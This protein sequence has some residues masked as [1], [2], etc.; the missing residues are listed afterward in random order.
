M[1]DFLSE[2]GEQLRLAAWRRHDRRRRFG[3][4]WRGGRGK[5]VAGALLALVV[6]APAVA[7]TGVWRPMLGDGVS[8]PPSASTAPAAESQRALLSVLRRPQTPADRGARTGYA[9]GFLGRSVADVRTTEIR[10]LH[11]ESDGRGIVLIP[12]GRYGLDPDGASPI[13]RPSGSDGLCVFAEDRDHGQPAGGG[14]GCYSTEQLLHGQLIAGLG[15]RVYGL[16]PD[17]VDKLQITT[18][19]TTLTVEVEQ[20]FFI[21][22]GMLG[23]GEIRWLDKTGRV[24]R[25]IPGAPGL[26]SVPPPRHAPRACTRTASM[27]RCT[28]LPPSP[29]TPPSTPTPTVPASP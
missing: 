15:Q 26:P 25:T 21:Y 28:I 9:L 2:Y 14:F 16:V 10:L 12:V 18:A 3:F 22:S 24:L 29:H 8:P 13:P 20:N 17:G 5:R 11:V 19:N 4:G 7:A 27:L 6:A 23:A 1:S